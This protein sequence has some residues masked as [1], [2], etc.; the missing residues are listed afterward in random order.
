M[1]ETFPSSYWLSHV[2]IEVI[3]NFRPVYYEKL[4][5]KFNLLFSR[6]P[7]LSRSVLKS[8]FW[9]NDQCQYTT[10]PHR[11]ELIPVKL[12]EPQIRVRPGQILFPKLS[13]H[14]VIETKSH[15]MCEGVLLI[16]TL[17]IF[18]LKI[19]AF[20]P[21]IELSTFLNHFN[22]LEVT[23]TPPLEERGS[24]ERFMNSF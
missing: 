3:I 20:H 7:L 19:F 9:S 22:F 10:P 23:L 2:R 4:K 13:L 5:K 6:M 16:T 8:L 18:G 1:V 21:I 15:D 11:S 24:S 12:W 14:Q 17:P